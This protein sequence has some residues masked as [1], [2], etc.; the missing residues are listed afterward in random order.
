LTEESMNQ[1]ILPLIERLRR[2]A[3]GTES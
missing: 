2:Q 1:K 3:K